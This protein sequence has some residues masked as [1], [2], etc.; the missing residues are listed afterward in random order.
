[1]LSAIAWMVLGAAT[2]GFAFGFWRSPEQGFYAAL[3]LPLLL[4]VLMLSTAVAN[5][6]FAKLMG[7]ALGLLQCLCCALIT[8]AILAIIIAAATPVVFLFIFS[9]ERFGESLV[10]A[11]G[12]AVQAA[13]SSAQKLLAMHVLL[14][15]VAGLISLQRLRSLLSKL[16]DS[17][18]RATQFFWLCLVVQGFVGTQ[19]CWIF[20]PYLGKP[21]LPVQ[22]FRRDALSGSFIEEV[23]RWIG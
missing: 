23:L 12:A 19:L 8:M 16:I 17:R 18:L 14:I 22:F 15:G 9:V 21:F 6:V 3:K 1:M 4:A 5:A 13:T 20:R 10:G 11:T 2:Y 7:T